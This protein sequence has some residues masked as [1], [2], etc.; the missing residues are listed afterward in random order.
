MIIIKD[1]RNI[2]HII[3]KLLNI[4][5]Q[6]LA[7]GKAAYFWNQTYR[8]PENQQCP[9]HILTYFVYNPPIEESKTDSEEIPWASHWYKY[10]IDWGGDVTEM[11]ND[12][13]CQR[14]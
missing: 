4:I 5:I 11:K 7:L 14:L 10:C 13:F 2:F 8:D 9:I 6:Y 12:T 1:T 3:N